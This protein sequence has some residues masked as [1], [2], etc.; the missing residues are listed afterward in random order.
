M[1]YYFKQAVMSKYQPKNIPANCWQALIEHKNKISASSLTDMFAQDPKR[2]ENF[3]TTF[4]G[5]FV[6]YSKNYFNRETLSLLFT[7]AQSI[8]LSTTIKNFFS[9]AIVNQTENSAAMH[10]ALRSP[11]DQAYFVDGKN[12]SQLVHAELKNMQKF[13]GLLHA[14][15]IKGFSGKPIKTV[16]N[17]GIGGSYLGA[18]L[19][20]QALADFSVT[21]IEM[22][23]VSNIDTQDIQSAFAKSDPSTTLFIIASKSFTTFETLRNAEIACDWLIENGCHNPQDQLIAITA[24]EVAAKKLGIKNDRIFHIWEWVGGRYSIWS[25]IG[26]PVAIKIGMKN[27]ND[28]LSGAHAVDQ[29]FLAAPLKSNLPVI[30]ALIDIWYINFFNARNFAVFPYDN[31]LSILPAYIGQLFMESNGKQIDN[32]GNKIPY[33]TAPVVW[34]GLGANAQ[35]SLF[36]ALYQGTIFSPIDFIVSLQTNTVKNRC[37]HAMV[38]NCLAQSATLMHGNIDQK[39]HFSYKDVSGNKPSTTILLDQLSPASLGSLLCLYEHRCFVHSCVWNTNPFDQWGVESSKVLS[40]EITQAL[41]EN[42]ISSSYDLSTKKMLA[43]YLD[44]T[45]S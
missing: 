32:D 35:H 45:K 43:Y 29:H 33:H 27:F 28:F 25:A 42:K 3:S 37:H 7:M 23:F 18:K 11:A 40:Q 22:H 15:A 13:I 31:A 1:H 12:I 38:A 41:M 44:K 19:V 21:D 9:G 17:I 2:A 34:G 6:D 5:L 20:T 8:N 16:I 24:N 39:M 10:M 4:N 30:L 14:N 26:L 36:Q